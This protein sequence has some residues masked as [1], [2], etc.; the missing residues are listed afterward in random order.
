M[1]YLGY[2]RWPFDTLWRKDL[3]DAYVV[4][5]DGTPVG[6]WYQGPFTTPDD[7]EIGRAFMHIWN[8]NISFYVARIGNVTLTEC[9]YL[10]DLLSFRLSR[11]AV[12]KG[13]E[14]VKTLMALCYAYGH[15]VTRD[16]QEARQL[17][18]E[19][20][21]AGDEDAVVCRAILKRTLWHDLADQL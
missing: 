1:S 11:E 12:E 20:A 6:K 21:A 15:E 7:A 3:R 16:M 19:R 4:L 13:N 18:N 9:K 14:R 17:L 10:S 2:G 5:Q 8:P